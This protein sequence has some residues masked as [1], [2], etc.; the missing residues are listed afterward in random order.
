MPSK[1]SVYLGEQLIVE[2]KLVYN[3]QISNYGTEKLPEAKGFW[4]EELQ[5][6]KNP[7]S[8]K[9][10]IDGEEFYSAVIKRIALFPTES[11]TLELDPMI[12][13]CEVVLPRSK[14]N[15]RSQ[16]DS[17]FDDSFF[18]SSMFD[19][20]T[21]KR[22]IASPLSIE[23]KPLPKYSSSG[24]TP[25]VMENVRVT[26]NIDTTEITR[27]KALTLKYNVTGYGNIN[28]VDFPQPELPEY[29]EVFPPKVNKTSR[30]K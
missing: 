21:V 23:V 29:A 7:Q 20:T 14:R 8:S 24:I 28:S 17:F 13:Q 30:K 10:V 1:K 18:S 11:G 25:P 2:Y 16:F 6:I 22:V 5:E 12:T 3:V 9:I 4:L 15:S 26:G 27:D 19:R